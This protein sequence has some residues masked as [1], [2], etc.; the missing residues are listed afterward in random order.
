MDLMQPADNVESVKATKELLKSG[1]FLFDLCKD[2]AHLRSVRFGSR[3]CTDFERKYHLFV[4]ES[5]AE[6]WEISQNRHYLWG[7]NFWWMCDC[8]AFKEIL[9]YERSISQICRWAQ[10][11]L[12][13]QFTILYRSYKMMMDVGALSRRFGPLIAAHCA[14]TY[15][16]HTVDIKNKPEVYD[17]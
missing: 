9:E 1:E 3:V 5:A 12:G 14:I 7:N 11:L 13:Y 4:G 15:I 10:E 2:G 16:L 17:E 8:A 6:R